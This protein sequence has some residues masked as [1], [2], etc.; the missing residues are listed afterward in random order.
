MVSSNEIT[1]HFKYDFLLFGIVSS[2]RDYKLAWW[3]NQQ[4]RIHLIKAQD[5][6]LEINK[7]CTIVI[8]N[9]IFKTAH[10]TFRLLKNGAYVAAGQQPEFLLPDQQHFDYWLKI[11][12]P[13][14]SLRAAAIRQQVSGVPEVMEV[15][16]FDVNT[17]LFKENLIF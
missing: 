2:A 11:E 6:K 10:C 12:D 5:L 9:F 13:T 1:V 8:A 16:H 3:L 17:L 14:E 4:L 7:D 15:Q